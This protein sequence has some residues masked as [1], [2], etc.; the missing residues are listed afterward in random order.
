[1]TTTTPPPV[2]RLDA[3]TRVKLRNV[4]PRKERH[5]D[6]LKQAIDLDFEWETQNLQ[7]AMFGADVLDAFYT[8]SEQTEA[9]TSVDGVPLVKPNLRNPLLVM[10]VKWELEDEGRDVTVKPA[11]GKSAGVHVALCRAKKFAFAMKEGGSVVITWQCQG[12]TDLDV[13]KVGRLCAMEGEP[14][15]L[16][17]TGATVK[18]AA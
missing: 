18:A 13:D 3:P 12:N 6:E 2:F 4:S 8:R 10:P 15:D 7:L 14:V 1:M 5:G 9:Q 11:K 16:T 17:L